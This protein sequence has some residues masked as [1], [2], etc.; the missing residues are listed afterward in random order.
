MDSCSNPSYALNQSLEFVRD[1]IGSSDA[2]SYVCKFVNFWQHEETKTMKYYRKT[3]NFLCLVLYYFLLPDL[4]FLYPK[5]TLNC[6][7][8]SS[9]PQRK[10]R[11]RKNVAAVVGGSYSSVSVQV[12]EPR[13]LQSNRA[14]FSWLIY[15]DFFA[16]LKSVQ[17]VQTRIYQIKIDSNSLRGKLKILFLI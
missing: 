1:M 13:N 4:Q 7:R 15:Y 10:N 3:Q 12:F 14:C 16:L 11:D 6:F 9:K 2:S 8:D 5:I 17:R